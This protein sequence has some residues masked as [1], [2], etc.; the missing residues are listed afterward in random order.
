M[1]GLDLGVGPTGFRHGEFRLDGQNDATIDASFVKHDAPDDGSGAAA[2]IA[3]EI[4][5]VEAGVRRAGR[6]VDA[7]RA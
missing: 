7:Q 6:L 5:H 2:G 4:V 1:A 3:L